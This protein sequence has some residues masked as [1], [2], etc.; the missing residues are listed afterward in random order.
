MGT[1]AFITATRNLER[2]TY[3][4]DIHEGTQEGPGTPNIKRRELPRGAVVFAIGALDAYL[5]EVAAEVMVAQVEHGHATGDSRKILETIS[6]SCR[7]WRS[8]WQSLI[9][10][11][12]ASPSS[13]KRS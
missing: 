2:A 12:T 4:L 11:L 9:L 13:A 7:L 10:M 5:S 6:V 3:F 8:S 1:T